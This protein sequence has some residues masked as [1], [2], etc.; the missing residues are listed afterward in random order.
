MS[1]AQ[2]LAAEL[3]LPAGDHP[4]R[5]VVRQQLITGNYPDL[6][7][8]SKELAAISR[9]K[10]INKSKQSVIPVA[11]IEEFLLEPAALS[12][13]VDTGTRIGKVFVVD[14][15]DLMDT[16]TQNQVLKTLE[17]P[18]DGTLIILVSSSE[19]ELLPT[20]RSRCQRVGFAPLSAQALEAWV[21]A[22]GLD[23]EGAGALA[24]QRQWLLAYGQGS[25]GQLISAMQ[26]QLFAWHQQLD[27]PLTALGTPGKAGLGGGLSA[28]MTRLVEERAAAWVEGHPLR[29]QDAAN[30]LWLR[31]LLAFVAERTRRQLSQSARLG[32]GARCERLATW[33]DHLDHAEG[34]I[35]RNVFV[36]P[37]LDNLVAQMASGTPALPGHVLVR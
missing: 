7:V 10:T 31:R 1:T 11:V 16:R 20:I 9:E 26:N 18:P 23:L 17:E 12:R 32:D 35:D 14:E 13:T 21:Q 4:L 37:I 6:H 3:M 33:L 28:L 27:A 24:G 36:A 29:S 5:E 19:H 8:I 25:P 22:R 34:L 30:R 2:A 15:A